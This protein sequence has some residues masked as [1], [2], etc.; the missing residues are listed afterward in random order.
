[1]TTDAINQLM[2][3]FKQQAETTKNNATVQRVLKER[4]HAERV[5]TE[6]EPNPIPTTTP[7]AAPTANP[8]T[9]FSDLKIEYPNSDMGRPRQ[10][11]V[12]SQDNYKSISPPSA[13][14]RHQ[15]RGRTIIEDFLFHM[16]DVPTP[17]Q[18]FT[19]QQAA[20]RK[21]PLQFLC[22]RISGTQQQDW[23]PS[24]LLPSVETSKIQRRMEQVFWQG[25]LKPHNNH[26]DHCL[27]GKAR[28]TPSKMQCHHLWMD[29]LQLLSQE[30]RPPPHAYHNGGN[31][32]NSPNDCGTPTAD[33]LTVKLLF[34]SVISTP[35]A[36]FM[37]I[38]IKNFYLMTPMDRYEY[39]RM[40]LKVFLQDIINEYTLRDKV[41]ADG[42]VSCKV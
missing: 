36:M 41:E 21:F 8:T 40:K 18:H 3:F 5:L 25:N 31:S 1:M 24:G 37:I 20:L 23:G 11:P 35:N 17:T 28:H 22:I 9:T 32:I 12:V 42:N 38:D 34:N 33:I 10:T 26:R 6:A 4:A 27:H 15:R 29:C 16:I 7:S 2:P 19:N 14:T 39:F 13:N 30:E